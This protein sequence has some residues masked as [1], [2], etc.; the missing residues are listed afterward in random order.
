MGTDRKGGRALDVISDTANTLA[1]IVI[2]AL[3][4][5]VWTCD[6]LIAIRYPEKHTI[7][8]ALLAMA[9]RY[10][11]IP[12]VIGL[13]IGHLLWPQRIE[14]DQYLSRNNGLVSGS[15]QASPIPPPSKP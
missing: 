2:V 6:V 7:S 15:H 13:L 3:T 10:P 8:E 1:I 9:C 11:I 14:K 4:L 12:F 5:V